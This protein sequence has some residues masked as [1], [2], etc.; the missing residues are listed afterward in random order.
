MFSV[1]VRKGFFSVQAE[2]IWGIASAQRVFRGSE[3]FFDGS[4]DDS[5]GFT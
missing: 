5:P 3:Y 1:S 4:C 2:S